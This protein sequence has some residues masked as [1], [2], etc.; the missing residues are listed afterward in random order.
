MTITHQPDRAALAMI[1]DDLDQLAAVFSAQFWAQNAKQAK[2]LV[3]TLRRYD[4]DGFQAR[5]LF[6]RH[7]D[8]A[9]SAN[10][11]NQSTNQH[12][13]RART[14]A[15]LVDDPQLIRQLITLELRLGNIWEADRWSKR[16]DQ[17]LTL[18]EVAMGVEEAIALAGS[19]SPEDYDAD[20]RNFAERHQGTAG[21]RLAN[22]I[23]YDH[24]A[25]NWRW[26]HLEELGDDPLL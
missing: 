22:E 2:R 25:E 11:L 8:L 9:A 19:T 23:I 4:H 12:L 7:L 10:Q 20:C 15:V 6:S 13:Y 16:I 5:R 1:A 3:D 14:L 18:A 21:L 24:I 26:L 17:Q